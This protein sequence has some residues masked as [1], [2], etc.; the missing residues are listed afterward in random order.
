M[1][2]DNSFESLVGIH[3]YTYAQLKGTGGTIKQQNQDFI[4]REIPP[5]GKPIFKGSEIGNDVGGLFIHA[6]LWKTGLDT[7]NAIRKLSNHLKHPERDFGFAGLKDAAAETY[8]RISIW[9]IDKE[10]IKTINLANIKVFHPIRQKFSVKIGD[11]E[12][13]FFEIIIRDILDEWTIEEWEDFKI[14]LES[15]GILN[16]YGLQRFG[17]TRPILHLIGKLLLQGEYSE[18]IHK[19]LGESSPLENE[20][21]AKL[22]LEYHETHSYNNL[23]IKFPESYQI[24]K[25]LLTGLERNHTAKTIIL[26]LPK[27]FLKLAISAYQSYL[28]NKVLS[29]LNNVEFPLSV[30]EAIPLPGYQTDR[31]KIPKMISDTVTLFLEEDALNFQSF[32]HE[33]SNLRSKGSTRQAIIL[34]TKFSYSQENLTEKEKRVSFCLPKGSYGTVVIREIIKAEI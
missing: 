19:Y 6:V 26:N 20:R 31:K 21:I 14:N 8:Q 7:F 10:L 3:G 12:G 4:V 32:N 27:N 2:D 25:M 13:N 33:H 9:N 34:P 17:T 24:E 15:N 22:R 30:N 29:Y 1:S 28:F 23:R 5:S 11:L 16:F 18:V